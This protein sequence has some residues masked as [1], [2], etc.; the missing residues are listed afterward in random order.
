MPGTGK[1]GRI[2]II[3]KSIASLAL[4]TAVLAMIAIT[5]TH[6]FG[7]SVS[8]LVQFDHSRGQ[9]PE[10]I[11]ISKTGDIFVTLAPIHGHEGIAG[12][13]RLDLCGAAA[14]NN[15]GRNHGSQ[16]N[17]YVLLNT[18][19]GQLSNVGQLWRISRDGTTQTRSS[20]GDARDLNGA[21]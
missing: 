19:L 3:R 6:A 9:L 14:A 13:D 8:W 20:P 7:Q 5:Q 4:A 15:P 1:P 2:G 18:V 21:L 16:G 17:L 12:R 11:A 10:S